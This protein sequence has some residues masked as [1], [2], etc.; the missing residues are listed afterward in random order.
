MC[1]CGVRALRMVLPDKNSRRIDTLVSIIIRSARTPEQPLSN[2]LTHREYLTAHKQG[3]IT[4]GKCDP[5]QGW[6]SISLIYF[7]NCFVPLGFL[8]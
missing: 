8:P 6:G 3:G 7:Y 5:Q 1:V 2:M 4:G